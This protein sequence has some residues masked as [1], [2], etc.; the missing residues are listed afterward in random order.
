MN[1]KTFFWTHAVIGGAYLMGY[2]VG[3][4]LSLLGGIGVWAGISFIYIVI[5]GQKQ[6]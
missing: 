6:P 5:C 4:T 2:I 3:R 1:G